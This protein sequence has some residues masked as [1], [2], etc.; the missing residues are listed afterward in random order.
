[1]I[2]LFNNGDNNGAIKII[3]ES[4]EKF[5]CHDF[6]FETQ[7]SFGKAFAHFESSKNNDPDDIEVN[8]PTYSSKIICQLLSKM[9][10]ADYVF[11]NLNPSE[12]I[13]T[14]KLV[15]ELVIKNK[16]D[17]LLELIE[18][19]KCQLTNDNWLQL[20]NDIFGM[21]I[22]DDL[23]KCLVNYF[24]YEILIKDTSQFPDI[25]DT[26]KDIY[27][28]L[29]EIFEQYRDK[30]ISKPFIRKPINIPFLNLDPDIIDKLRKEID[31]DLC[32]SL[33]IETYLPNY[34]EYDP[35]IICSEYKKICSDLSLVCDLCENIRREIQGESKKI[36]P[37]KRSAY[38]LFI[39][40][41]L[42]KQRK[43]NP[44]L[45]NKEY[46]MRAAKKWNVQKNKKTG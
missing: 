21:D 17:I 46:L 3:S 30:K 33:K 6:V 22:F 41:E 20:L 45:L 15:D 34:S 23:Q 10:S 12:I 28:F 7:C 38:Q 40:N 5:G 29:Q 18:L 36:N 43:K 37:E 1:M 11:N 14:I 2:A 19:F 35:D 13:L 4:G 44:G 8:L 26:P 24:I 9:Y 31:N 42:K 32:T 25:G 27:N 16:S 39:T